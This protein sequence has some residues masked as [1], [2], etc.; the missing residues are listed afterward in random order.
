MVSEV[1]SK[2]YVYHLVGK[3]WCVGG[4]EF[5][6]HYHRQEQVKRNRV[7]LEGE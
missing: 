7:I 3:S 6:R 5:P 1:H 4:G 2:I